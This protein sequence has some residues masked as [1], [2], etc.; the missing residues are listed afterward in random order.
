MEKYRHVSKLDNTPHLAVQEFFHSALQF[1]RYKKYLPSNFFCGIVFFE[2]REDS[3]YSEKALSGILGGMRLRGFVGGIILRGENHI[4]PATG[5]ILLINSDTQ[6]ESNITIG[7]PKTSLISGDANCKTVE[8]EN[9]LH[10]GVMILWEEYLFSQFAFDVLAL[11]KGTFQK[12]RL[13]S[14]HGIGSSK[15]EE[16]RKSAT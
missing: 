8:L 10:V 3:Q 15:S 16:R 12:G 9:H 5:R 11:M 2:L 7:E 14:I 6:M 4:K 1:Q 13:S